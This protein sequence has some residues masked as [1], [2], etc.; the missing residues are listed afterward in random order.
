MV[1]G[2]PR[3]IGFC[4]LGSRNRL[5]FCSLTGQAF[6]LESGHVRSWLQPEVLK[7]TSAAS[8][9]S[10]AARA[11]ACD[12]WVHVWDENYGWGL[13]RCRCLSRLSRLQPELELGARD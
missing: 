3:R 4:S 12:D 7:A 9:A 2:L 8:P 10:F 5:R 1:T 13:C 6:C 11:A